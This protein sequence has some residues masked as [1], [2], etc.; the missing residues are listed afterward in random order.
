MII[1]RDWLISARKDR[2]LIQEQ[3][4]HESGISRQYYALIESGERGA[5]VHTAKK[6]AAVL[7]FPWEKFY[8]EKSDDEPA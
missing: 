5:P 6:I 7:G 8:E 3:V 4:A 2:G 1:R